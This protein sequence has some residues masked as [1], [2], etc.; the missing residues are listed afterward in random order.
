MIYH[1]AHLTF[2]S[3]KLFRLSNLL[4]QRFYN[5]KSLKEPNSVIIFAKVTKKS[6]CNWFV[7]NAMELG[8]PGQHAKR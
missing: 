5:F 1:N 4:K 8:N 2:S 3:L 7:P 6:W